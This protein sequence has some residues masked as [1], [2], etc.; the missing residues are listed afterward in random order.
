[1]FIENI[2]SNEIPTIDLHDTVDTA[3]QYMDDWKVFHL[4]VLREGKYA[5]VVEEQMLLGCD[6]H[7]E[8]SEFELLDCKVLPDQNIYHAIECITDFRLSVLPV[9]TEE[10]KFLGEVLPVHVLEEVAE[11]AA[12]HNEGSV[13]ILEMNEV[14]YSLSDIARHVESNDARVLSVAIKRL[15]DGHMQQV[16]IKVNRESIRG[17]VQTLQRF[18]YTIKAYFDAPNIDDDLKRRY[19]ELMRYLDT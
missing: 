12:V 10:G 5:G 17:V 9:V 11:L 7:K 16:Y 18:N 8:I 6:G 19:D 3:L 14:D 2:I 4:I 13:I 15:G 1:M